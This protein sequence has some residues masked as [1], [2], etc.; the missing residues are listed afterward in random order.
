MSRFIMVI[1]N[2]QCIKGRIHFLP[3]YFNINKLQKENM[4]D[5]PIVSIAMNELFECKP[6]LGQDDHPP[7]AQRS[8]FLIFDREQV[9]K[10]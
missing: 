6:I 8:A 10:I 2:E 1:H 9:S 3:F 4:N 7:V 5:S